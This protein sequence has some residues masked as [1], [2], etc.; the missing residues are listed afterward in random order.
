MGRRNWDVVRVGEKGRE[1]NL[2]RKR[3][4]TEDEKKTDRRVKR[5]NRTERGTLD[6]NSRYKKKIF[7]LF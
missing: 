4:F 6:E 3:G 2:R 1:E 5:R 7:N